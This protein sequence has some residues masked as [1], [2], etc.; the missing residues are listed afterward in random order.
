MFLTPY[1]VQEPYAHLFHL[2]Q[3]LL[4]LMA[5]AVVVPCLGILGFFFH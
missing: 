2:A 1:K 5:L 3:A 4:L